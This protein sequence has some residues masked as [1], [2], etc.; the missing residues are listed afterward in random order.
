MRTT[1]IQTTVVLLIFSLLFSFNT[2]AQDSTRLSLPEGA[3]ARLGKGWINEIAYSPDGTR[4]AVAGSIGIWLYNT[5]T[6]Q[7]VTLLT[8]HTDTVFSVAFSPDGNTLASGSGNGTI[9]L[10]DVDSGAHQRTLTGHTGEVRSVAFSPDGNR[11]TS[12][13]LDSTIRLWDVDSGAHQR[14]FTGHTG[15]VLSVAFSPDGNTLA[16]GSLDSTCN[17]PQNLGS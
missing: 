13:S 1:Y 17:Y 14:T 7:A 8:G 3:K 11:L 15:W 16:S 10:W 9:R 5:A 12:G 4:L 6:H 2:L